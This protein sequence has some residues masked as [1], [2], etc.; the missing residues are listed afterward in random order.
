[1]RGCIWDHR[2]LFHILEITIVAI[3]ILLIYR[4]F[5]ITFFIFFSAIA[6]HTPGLHV[7]STFFHTNRASARWPL[8]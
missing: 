8:H 5:I 4:N 1:V 6:T 7:Y 2:C 3:S